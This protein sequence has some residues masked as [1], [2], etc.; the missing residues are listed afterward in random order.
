MSLLLFLLRKFI[1]ARRLGIGGRKDM[2][3]ARRWY[4]KVRVFR[5]IVSRQS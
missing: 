2:D 4:E 5:V 1:D 3:Q